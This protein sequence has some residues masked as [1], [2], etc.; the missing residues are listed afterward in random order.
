MFFLLFSQQQDVR[1]E[2]DII[3]SE[4]C[5]RCVV[6]WLGAY[7]VWHPELQNLRQA[8]TLLAAMEGLL[9]ITLKSDKGIQVTN[10]MVWWRRLAAGSSSRSASKTTAIKPLAFLPRWTRRGISRAAPAPRSWFTLILGLSTIKR[11]WTTF[12]HSSPGRTVAPD[13]ASSSILHW[14]IMNYDGFLLRWERLVPILGCKPE[15]LWEWSYHLHVKE[16]AT[17]LF[18][19]TSIGPL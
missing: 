9:R 5:V 13:M 4:T 1:Q 7:Q 14:M 3:Q 17:I 10:Q 12:N 18:L 11:V 16:Y 2:S 15:N 8:E 19:L 6:V